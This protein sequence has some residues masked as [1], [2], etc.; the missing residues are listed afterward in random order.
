MVDLLFS[1]GF[2]MHLLKIYFK[3]FHNQQEQ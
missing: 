2:A 1:T 3:N